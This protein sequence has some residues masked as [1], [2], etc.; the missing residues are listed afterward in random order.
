MYPKLESPV[1]NLLGLEPVHLISQFQSS[2]H[3]DT[4]ITRM[5]QKNHHT[6][7]FSLALH[8]CLW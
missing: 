8:T 2:N 1:F 4:H 5:F 6:A 3:I 7:L